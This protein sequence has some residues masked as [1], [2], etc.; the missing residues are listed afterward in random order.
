MSQE[1]NRARILSVLG[2]IP[3]TQSGVEAGQRVLGSPDQHTSGY[4]WGG[5]QKGSVSQGFS[6]KAPNWGSETCLRDLRQDF[7]GI[8]MV[9]LMGKGKR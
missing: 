4:G 2:P 7:P 9:R 1:T 3:S 5:P 6:G 8:L